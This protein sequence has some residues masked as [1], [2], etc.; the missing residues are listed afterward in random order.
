MLMCGTPVTVN[1]NGDTLPVERIEAGQTLWNPLTEMDVRVWAVQKL[2]LAGRSG[3]RVRPVRIATD[4]LGPAQPALSLWVLPLQQILRPVRRTNRPVSLEVMEVGCLDPV[5]TVPDDIPPTLAVLL[6]TEV[7]SLVEV[8]GILAC[9]IAVE[10]ATR[11]PAPGPRLTLA[12][13]RSAP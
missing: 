13:N 2:H 8:A 12:W 4:A 3:P 1:R 5:A 7:P 11:S 9:T 6:L 10:T